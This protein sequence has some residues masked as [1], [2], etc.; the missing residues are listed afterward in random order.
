MA[1][2]DK[3]VYLDKGDGT[4]LPL[5]NSGKIAMLW[6]GPWDIS[7][8][9]KDVDFGVQILPADVSHATIAGPDMYV[10]LDN[11]AQQMANSWAFI[12]WFTSA[13]VH[14]DYA[15][16]TGHLPIRESETTLPAYQKYLEKYPSSSV[17]VDNLKNVTKARPNITA[18]P[19][20]SI[21]L[22]QAVQAILLGKSQPKEALDAAA[23]Q[24]DGILASGQ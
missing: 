10:M 16:A 1:V 2:T 20:I 13:E 4:Y 22:G 18:Y 17:F 12:Q 7:S 9:N 24:V 21:A 3:S 6:T 8:I 19:K 23:Q 15:I 11:G 5:F 14:L